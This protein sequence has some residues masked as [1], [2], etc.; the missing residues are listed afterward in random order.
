MAPPAGVLA[1]FARHPVAA[2]L[3]MIVM[4]LAGLTG[5]LKLNKQF[6]PTF[7]IA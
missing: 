7:N 1:V 4:L 3:L 5:F 2:N 6:L